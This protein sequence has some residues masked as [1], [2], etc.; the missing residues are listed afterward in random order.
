MS[1][2]IATCPPGDNHSQLRTTVL[3][4]SCHLGKTHT[5]HLQDQAH[6]WCGNVSVQC[7]FII[8]DDFLTL[9][10]QLLEDINLEVTL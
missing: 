6:T 1:A 5:C 7:M 2:D 4:C 10:Y 3:D 8:D 9:M